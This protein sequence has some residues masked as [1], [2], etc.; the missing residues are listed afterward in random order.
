MGRFR[1]CYWLQTAKI[2]SLF[3]GLY[4]EH[5]QFIDLLLV[6]PDFF[7]QLGNR[8]VQ[9][10][11]FYQL[12]PIQPLQIYR[13]NNFAAVFQNN[14][15]HISF[16]C[17]IITKLHPK[18]GRIYYEATIHKQSKTNMFICSRICFLPRR[19]YVQ[20]LLCHVCKGIGR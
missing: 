15:F 13:H 9:C 14:V 2:L 6:L 7:S 8:P 10:G 16:V 1:F 3:C 5:Q 4:M 19:K 20:S 12:F 11:L 17:S 18:R